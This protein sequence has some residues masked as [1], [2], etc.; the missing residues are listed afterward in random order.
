MGADT[1]ESGEVLHA[2]CSFELTKT[3]RKFL[4]PEYLDGKSKNVSLR[5]GAAALDGTRCQGREHAEL[6]AML[7]RYCC[8]TRSLLETLGYGEHLRL[9]F[10]SFRP[11]EVAGRS[12]TWQRDDTRLH[13]DAFP[14][15][16]TQ[17]LQIL[18]VFTN[19]NPRAARV[20][21][22]GEPFENVAARFL[23]PIRPP[24]PG[25]SLAL[26]LLR[27]VKGR[28]TEYDHIMLGI[29]DAMK[30]DTE[31]QSQVQQSQ[32]VFPP[33][34]TWACFADRVSHAAM[35]GQFA[36]EQTFYLPVDAMNDPASTP[37]RVLERL[38]R[39]TLA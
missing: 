34:V 24:L 5:P 39:R 7:Q 27:R 20:W 11:A 6:L 31:Y 25:S 30:A 8:S 4:S 9:G 13:V 37:L 23:P 1:L 29:H 21:R 10:T 12:T 17:G 35:S 3:E 36:L 38:A 15:R 16:P 14:A 33:G 22:I 26:Q 19:V 28:R 18:R 32:V 2:P